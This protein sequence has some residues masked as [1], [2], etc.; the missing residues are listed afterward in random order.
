[1]CLMFFL[2]QLVSIE[3]LIEKTNRIILIL[4]LFL[5]LIYIITYSKLQF[6]NSVKDQK[7]TNVNDCKD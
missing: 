6:N 7:K 1:M 5:V 4:N 2:L 3:I